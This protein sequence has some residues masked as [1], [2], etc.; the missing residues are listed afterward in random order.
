MFISYNIYY[1]KN[2]EK[3]LAKNYQKLLNEF[4][5]FLQLSNRSDHTLINYRADLLKFL[6]WYQYLYKARKLSKIDR[7]VIDNYMQFLST[8]CSKIARQI[9][10]LP[11]SIRKVLLLD[12]S[13]Y[14]EISAES[15]SIGSQK[16][17]LS[18]IK[19][20]FE[21]LRESYGENGQEF[22]INPVKSK[23]HG[24]RLKDV[25]I[26]HT[27][28]L[29]KDDWFK[30]NKLLLGGREILILNLMYYA[31]LRLSEVCRLEVSN[32][33]PK[34]HSIEA[35]RKGGKIHKFIPQRAKTIFKN[36][37]LHLRRTGITTGPIFLGRSDQVISSKTMY[38]QIMKI[39]K[40][41]D[42]SREIT[43][44]SFRKACATQLYF[45]HKDILAVRD[46]LNH[47]DAAVTQTYI[48]NLRVI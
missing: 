5:S 14:R 18:T 11:V 34:L 40:R 13:D 44:H 7:K 33:D 17:H 10:W 24:I 28:L 41:A 43:P 12:L 2:S 35:I 47:A 31:G 29:E 37:D 21:F 4:L 45:K 46:Y 16:R 27:K 8:G 32:F 26:Q 15:L 1:M 42:I 3:D 23:L 25:D 6:F 30:I 19:N 38:N 20:F 48:E 39:L 9:S 36:L 22:M